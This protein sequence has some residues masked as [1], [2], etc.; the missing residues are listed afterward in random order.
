[1]AH[2]QRMGRVVRL[3]DGVLVE[4][5]VRADEKVVV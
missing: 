5:E 2:A 4:A 3:T 1:M